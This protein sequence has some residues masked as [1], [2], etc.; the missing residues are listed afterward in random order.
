[1]YKAHSISDSTKQPTYHCEMN[2]LNSLTL[3]VVLSAST[4]QG[5]N[6]F[7]RIGSVCG[8]YRG[9]PTGSQCVDGSCRA[10]GEVHKC[11]C[12]GCT[13]KAGAQ[14]INK[15]CVPDNITKLSRPRA[16][17]SLTRISRN[18]QR[19]PP[20]VGLA[21]SFSKSSLAFPT[22]NVTPT[23]SP[24]V[25]QTRSITPSTS[26]HP[27][28]VPCPT[29]F[30][31]N[32]DCTCTRTSEADC[33]PCSGGSDRAG[34]DYCSQLGHNWQ[35]CHLNTMCRDKTGP[36]ATVVSSYNAQTQFICSATCD[37]ICLKLGTGTSNAG[38]PGACVLPTA[39]KV[40]DPSNP[41]GNLAV[42]PSCADM[43]EIEY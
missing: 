19:L 16:T 33:N 27:C 18:F 39:L 13:C 8:T 7:T 11:D 2:Y 26:S 1:M 4:S 14:C 32:Q 23:A 15:V 10:K 31:H 20:P 25:S 36:F 21:D 12:T 41:A 30:T 17:H 6:V 37:T 24:T 42:I 43:I 5:A 35:C 22:P 28:P 34:N 29:C 38:H 40:K 3:F 9:C